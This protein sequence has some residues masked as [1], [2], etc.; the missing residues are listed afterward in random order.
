MPATDLIIPEE[1]WQAAAGISWLIGGKYTLAI[2][3]FYKEMDNLIEFK[4]GESIFSKPGEGGMGDVWEQ[5]VAQGHG[6]S[7]GAEFFL[8]KKYGKFTGW[9]SYTLA[10]TTRNFPNINYGETFSYKYDRRHD[11]SIVMMYEKNKNVNFGLTWVYGSGM[12]TTLAKSEFIG[13]FGP[14]GFSCI[15]ETFED[16]TSESQCNYRGNTYYG[17]RNNYRL[18]AYHRLDISANVSKDKK[19]G[20]RTWSFGLYNAYSHINPF[21]AMLVNKM[22]AGM[23]SEK[24]E[25]GKTYL[26]IISIFPVMP[27]ISYKFVW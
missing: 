26:K 21:Y 23:G 6:T 10:Q 20:R 14:G 22:N 1:S 5:K 13:P 24:L 17:N 27:S 8:E 25:Y 15:G 11:I 3:G 12:P 16:G 2:E 9:V 7:Y 18:P 4:E 19:H